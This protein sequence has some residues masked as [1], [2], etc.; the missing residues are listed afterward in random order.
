VRY[1][2]NDIDLLALFFEIHADAP[3]KLLVTDTV[4]SMDGDLAKLATIVTLC[5]RHNVLSMV[6]EAHAAGVIGKGRGLAAELGL[7]DQVDVHM[8]TFSKGFGSFG[9]YVAGAADIIE[10]LR[11]KGRPFIYSTS[12]PPATVGASLAAVRYVRENPAMGDFLLAMAAEI[13]EF[14]RSCGLD[15][16]ASETAIIPVIIGEN[17]KTLAAR[18]KLMEQGVFVGAIRPPTVPEGTSRL[19]ISLRADLTNDDLSLFKRAV[20]GM[21][22]IM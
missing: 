19:R 2:L 10:Y 8:G 13:R 16:G 12:L 21:M 17:G 14:L 3:R 6:D 9:A 4:F 5:Q 1:R 18:E 20:T 22:E 15:T 11:N 7:A